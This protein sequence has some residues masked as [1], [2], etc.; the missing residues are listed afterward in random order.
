MVMKKFFYKGIPF[1]PVKDLRKTIEY[2]TQTLGFDGEWYWGDPPT[3]AGCRRDQLSLLFNVNPKLAAKMKGLELVMFVDD[4]DG[5]YEE[6]R[7]KPEVEI[8]IPIRDEPW[9]MREFTLRDINGYSLRISCSL[10]RIKKFGTPG[11][12]ENP[13]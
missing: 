7:S 3:D 11:E 8:I 9:G 4:V 1:L 6:L 13:A 10:E 12:K 2:Y 5:I